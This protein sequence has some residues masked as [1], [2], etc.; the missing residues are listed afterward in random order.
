MDVIEA[1]VEAVENDPGRVNLH[2]L[3]DYRNG[4]VSIAQISGPRENL[5]LYVQKFLANERGD[6]SVGLDSVDRWRQRMA[7]SAAPIDLKELGIDG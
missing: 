2:I 1:Y 6:G 4:R 5:A 3:L 7:E